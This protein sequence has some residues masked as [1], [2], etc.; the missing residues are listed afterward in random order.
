MHAHA[1]GQG[2]RTNCRACFSVNSQTPQPQAYAS[3]G[4]EIWTKT[5]TTAQPA[6]R[7]GPSKNRSVAAANQ[8]RLLIRLDRARCLAP[9]RR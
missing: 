1:P 2:E 6:A 8:S 3:R 5:E 4:P 7:P 9:G